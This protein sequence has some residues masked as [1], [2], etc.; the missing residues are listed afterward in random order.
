MELGVAVNDIYMYLWVYT[1]Q[2]IK[3]AYMKFQCMIEFSFES[4]L[5][6]LWMAI[7]LFVCLN[8]KRLHF[9]VCLFISALL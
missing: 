7:F 2:H 9:L 5:T 6:F 1:N 8:R 4:K 3:F